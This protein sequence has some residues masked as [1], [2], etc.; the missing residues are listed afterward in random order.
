MR[1]LR[2]AQKRDINKLLANNYGATQ[3]K[4]GVDVLIEQNQTV[5]LRQL[6]LFR[7]N[8]VVGVL[9]QTSWGRLP[10]KTQF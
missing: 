8:G 5:G 9:K 2:N 6:E 3:M 7:Q 10:N 4:E 1:S